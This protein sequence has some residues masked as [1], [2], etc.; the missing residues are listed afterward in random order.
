MSTP[1]TVQQQWGVAEVVL[2]PYQLTHVPYLDPGVTPD[3]I[4]GDTN[5]FSVP[6]DETGWV[7][8]T[9]I[10]MKLSLNGN[11]GPYTVV[12]TVLTQPVGIIAVDQGAKK[13]T[14]QGDQR[15]WF[16]ALDSLTVAGSTGNDGTY[17]LTSATLTLGDTVLLVVE[18]IPSPVA[19]GTV[20]STT[21]RTAL[22]VTPVIPS[23]TADGTITGPGVQL[24]QSPGAGRAII[25]QSYLTMV[26]PTTDPSAWG[27][28]AKTKFFWGNASNNQAFAA[29]AGP[30]ANGVLDNLSAASIVDQGLVYTVSG[31]KGVMLDT[32]NDTITVDGRGVNMLAGQD[33]STGGAGT[34]SL[35]VRM[36]YLV[37]PT[38][39]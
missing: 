9:T 6:G 14:V 8:G 39:F 20:V 24:V 3:F 32:T 11:N 7:K 18:A 23:D 25:P 21:H 17:T 19:D 38:G 15:S 35:L 22:Q 10:T 30:F 34:R 36:Y 12:S 27:Q 37:V 2:S 16:V 33:P 4:N 1:I 31:T 28:D 26:N 5:T 13:F 29:S